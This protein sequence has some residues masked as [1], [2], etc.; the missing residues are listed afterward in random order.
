MVYRGV[1]ERGFQGDFQ[2]WVERLQPKEMIEDL[3][4][5]GSSVAVSYTHLRSSTG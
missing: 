4:F 1:K 3:G 2:Q 5:A